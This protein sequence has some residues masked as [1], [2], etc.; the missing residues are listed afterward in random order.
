MIE[1]KIHIKIYFLLVLTFAS[2]L[3]GCGSHEIS[4]DKV[5]YVY[6][7]EARGKNKTLIK[8][9]DASSFKELEHPVYAVDKNHVYYK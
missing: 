8:D 1:R 5:Y 2:I 7:T 6:W 3:T 4:G 9:A